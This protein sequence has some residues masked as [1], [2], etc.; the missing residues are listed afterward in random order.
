MKWLVGKIVKAWITVAIIIAVCLV[1]FLQ[2]PSAQSTPIKTDPAI[3][4]V[5][6][7]RRVNSYPRQPWLAKASVEDQLKTATTCL[8]AGRRI[9]KEQQRMMTH[10]DV[11]VITAHCQKLA[12][13]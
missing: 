13:R 10:V 1:L 6:K 7:H 5:K 3:P 12:M 9:N 4:L 11:I 8:K 2:L